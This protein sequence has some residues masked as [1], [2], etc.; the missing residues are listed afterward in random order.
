MARLTCEVAARWFILK[1][2]NWSADQNEWVLS[3]VCAQHS[4][5]SMCI[6]AVVSSLF[7]FCFYFLFFSLFRCNLRPS[8]CRCQDRNIRQ[9]ALT[10]TRFKTNF[11]YNIFF[12]LYFIPTNMFLNLHHI[13]LEILIIKAIWHIL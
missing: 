2:E 11:I 3:R 7:S 5:H 13:N 4:S 6:A 10:A 8:T 1:N 9:Q 12:R